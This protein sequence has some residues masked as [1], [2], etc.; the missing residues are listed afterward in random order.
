MDDKLEGLSDAGLHWYN[1]LKAIERN[2]ETAIVYCKR[3]KLNI[4][5]LYD[6]RHQFYKTGILSKSKKNQI[7]FQKL[8]IANPEPEAVKSPVKM[9]FPNGVIVEMQEGSADSR[10]TALLAAWK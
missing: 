1:H 8:T 7:S 9:H 6:W 4:Q 10:I 5:T 3:H 2:R